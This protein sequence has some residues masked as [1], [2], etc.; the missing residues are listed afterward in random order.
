MEL[1][2]Q[3]KRNMRLIGYLEYKIAKASILAIIL[4][5]LS[6]LSLVYCLLTTIAVSMSKTATM[7]ERFI[8]IETSMGY[9]YIVIIN[10]VF[11]WRR[12]GFFEIVEL[13]QMKIEQRITCEAIY[14]R[15]NE[16]IENLVYV[17]KI[18]MFAIII[19]TVILPIMSFSYFNYYKRGMGEL[20]FS[21][22]CPA[23]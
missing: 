1:F 3:L 23:L 10:L 17:I 6:T 14:K 11:L 9:L 20:S 7:A 8:S 4:R 22:Y 18:F 13:M 5:I 2:V 19:P 15:Y 21:L 16:K 12:D